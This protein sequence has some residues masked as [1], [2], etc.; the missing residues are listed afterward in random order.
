MTKKTKNSVKST[1]VA[2]K[3]AMR[4]GAK[5]S[6]S[7]RSSKV[8]TVLSIFLLMTAIIGIIVYLLFSLKEQRMTCTSPAGNI[9]ITYDESSITGYSASAEVKYD[10]PSQQVYAG[11]VGIDNYLDEFQGWFEASTDGTCRR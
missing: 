6:A 9:T 5:K 3:D 4:S 8:I 10:L 2:V 7:S 1:D 11:S